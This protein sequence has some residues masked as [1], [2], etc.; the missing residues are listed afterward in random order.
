MTI[1]VK[2]PVRLVSDPDC[3]ESQRELLRHGANIAP[4]RDAEARVWQGLVG[5]IGATAIGGSADASTK[6]ATA[7]RSSLTRCIA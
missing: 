2:D 4:P 1:S 5:V 6:T 3:P 7:T